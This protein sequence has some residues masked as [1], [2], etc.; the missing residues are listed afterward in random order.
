MKDTAF[1]NYICKLRKE[2]GLTQTQLGKKLGLSNK[3]ISRWENGLSKPQGNCILRLAAILDTTADRILTGGKTGETI[4]S[5]TVPVHNA[6]PDPKSSHIN[7]IP[8]QAKPNGNYLCTWILQQKTA[9]RLGL[10]EKSSF[11][12]WRNC[13]N[14]ELLFEEESNYHIF[15]PEYRPGL[16]FLLDDGWDVPYDTD[17]SA[18]ERDIFGS[19]EPDQEKFGALGNSP[20][21]ILAAL[22]KKVK[23][24]GYAGL[25]LWVAPQRPGLGV[26][27]E[28]NTEEAREYW[29]AKAK[30]SEK[31]GVSYWKVDWGKGQNMHSYRKMMTECVKKYAPHLAIEHAVPQLPFSGATNPNCSLAESMRTEMQ[32]SDYFRTYDVSEPLEDCATVCRVY[33]LLQ[34]LNPNSLSPFVLGKINVENQPLVAAGLG[35]SLGIMFYKKETEAV[36]RWQRLAPPFSVKDADF[37]CSREQITDSIFF[38]RAPSS[39]LK[40]LEGKEATQTTPMVCARGTK[41]PKVLAHG[42]LPRI[43]ASSHPVT[44]NYAV[45]SLKRCI[46]PNRELIAAADVTIYPQNNRS[47]IGIF[48]YFNSLTVE[49]PENI[50]KNAA[51]YAQCLLCNSAVNVTKEVQIN[52]NKLTIP[53]R[54]LRLYG[55][56]KSNSSTLYDPCL[57]IQLIY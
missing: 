10:Y 16:Y 3:A 37:S 4:F 39:W 7:L 56:E 12:R 32:I 47:I 11:Q 2:K 25:G 26:D 55:N 38:S 28:E 44:H 43:L 29:I 57:A 46:D 13:L 5:N 33:S 45:A 8:K 27:V 41:L 51:V 14:T 34:G 30:E 18:A 21:Q 48:G 23:K 49:F 24:L 52:Q 9:D 40:Y 15:K 19:M 54:L 50:L 1:G 35:C 31:A 36:L 22:V 20:S 6:T 17:N 53:G 42:E